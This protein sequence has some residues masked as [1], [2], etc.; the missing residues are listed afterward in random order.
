MNPS[1]LI[2]PDRYKAAKLYSQIPNSGDGDLEF[3]RAYVATR[4]NA[5]GLIESVASGVP[6][7]DYPV[8]GGCP[9]LLLEPQ[10]TNVVL[11]SETFAASVG[12]TIVLNNTASPDGAVT[13]D[14]LVENT[15]T[16]IHI[17]TTGGSLGGSVD[18]SV[19][20][21]SVFAKAAGRTRINIFDNNQSVAGITNFDIANGVVISGTGKIENYGNGWYRCTIFPAKTLS[22]TSNVQIRLIDSGTNTSYTGNG[23]SGVFLWGAQVE[24]GVYPTSYIP[25]LGLSVT[26]L[27]DVALTASVPSLIGQ[28]EGTLFIE[29]ERIN[30]FAGSWF[31]LSNLAGTTANSYFDSIYFFQLPNGIFVVEAY[32]SNVQQFAFSGAGLSISKHKIAIGYKANDFVLYIDGVQIG[33]DTS[34]SVPAMNFLT[35]GGGADGG[36]QSQNV[37]IAAVYPTRLSNAELAQLTTL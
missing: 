3:S 30:L 16:G 13:A 31:I 35:I 33:T 27:A 21:V 15:S 32:I 2:I 12:T 28:T 19:Y 23:T 11:N 36:A 18:S 14:K 20:S 5:S 7:L 9:S 37:N 29:F 22:T 1:L 10:R 24:A 34:G 25:T 8:S 17:T 6:R 26:R 4:V